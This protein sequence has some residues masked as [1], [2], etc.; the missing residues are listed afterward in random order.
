[1]SSAL[2]KAISTCGSEAELARRLSGALGRRIRTGHIYQWKQHGFSRAAREDVVPA[3]ELVTAGASRCE[4]LCDD[5]AWMRDGTGTV[6][7]YVVPIASPGLRTSSLKRASTK[8][9]P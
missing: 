6:T 3:I 1:M 4:E 8:G 5:V 7:G 9:I 2:L